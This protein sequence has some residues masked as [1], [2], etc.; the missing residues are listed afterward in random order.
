LLDVNPEKPAFV[1]N[2]SVLT[3]VSVVAAALGLVAGC[4]PG[5]QP[6]R[7][8]AP[9]IGLARGGRWSVL[10]L[11]PPYLSGPFFTLVLK[12]HVLG[13]WVGGE[14]APPGALHVQIDRDSAAGF[15]PLGAVAIDFSADDDASVVDGMWNGSRVHFDVDPTRL[16]GSVADNALLSSRLS[17]LVT[18]ERRRALRQPVRRDDD[19][20]PLAPEPRD[21]SCQYVLDARDP[22][23][24][25]VG[26]SICAGMPQPT[27]LAVPSAAL[28][29]MTRPELLTVLTALLSAPPVPRSEAAWSSAGAASA[30][31]DWQ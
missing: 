6:V 25:F 26:T 31:V 8:G 19:Q 12:D 16:R 15:G 28:G 23:G 3:V 20:D 5:A 21:S 30:E 9:E 27:R 14:S 4:A 10:S 24:T 1:V 7:G 18:P 29:W 11:Q 2:R 22:D 13:G 17:P